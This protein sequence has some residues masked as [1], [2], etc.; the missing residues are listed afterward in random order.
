[1]ITFSS[2]LLSSHLLLCADDDRAE[3][4][5]QRTLVDHLKHALVASLL[6]RTVAQ[7]SFSGRL[8][9]ARIHGAN[10]QPVSQGWDCRGRRRTEKGRDGRGNLQTQALL[11]H[12][13]RGLL[14][15]L[16]PCLNHHDAG[17][18]LDHPWETKAY[19]TSPC[20]TSSA[21]GP[22]QLNPPRLRLQR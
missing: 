19:P 7:P 11:Y 21:W 16:P 2:T 17:G 20:P 10:H 5:A 3:M 6:L 18:H 8:G 15:S 12:P 13:S 14:G 1:M 22:A 9:S 4:D